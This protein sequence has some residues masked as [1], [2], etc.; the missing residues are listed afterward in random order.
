MRADGKWSFKD[1]AGNPYIEQWGAIYNPYAN[2]A[3]GMQ[4]Y[5]WFWFDE[6]GAMITGW[7]VDPVNGYTYYLNPQ[8]D[9]T[10][11][12]MMTGWVVIDGKEYYFNSES[13]GT[14][15][16]MFRNET[17]PDGYKVDANGVKIQ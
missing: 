9:G 3:E 4:N 7:F 14:R 16:R 2:T 1:A 10:M 15:G 13:D 5:D 8:S 12:R 11:G 6:T 17:T